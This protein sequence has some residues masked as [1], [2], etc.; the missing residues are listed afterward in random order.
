MTAIGV[1]PEIQA[2]FEFAYVSRDIAWGT[3]SI[4]LVTIFQP[5][6]FS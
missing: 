2:L 4:N 1:F 5:Y 3:S 6:Q